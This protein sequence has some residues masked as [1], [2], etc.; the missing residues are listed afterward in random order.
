MQKWW[1]EKGCGMNANEQ[2]NAVFDD[3][4]EEDKE[5]SGFDSCF[6]IYAIAQRD[7]GT[8]THWPQPSTTHFGADSDL[9]KYTMTSRW[10]IKTS[11]NMEMLG[12]LWLY[13]AL[14]EWLL[15]WIKDYNISFGRWQ[16]FNQAGFT[17]VIAA[18]LS[19]EQAGFRRQ[20]LGQWGSLQISLWF[21]YLIE[22]DITWHNT[23]VLITI[24]VWA[25]SYYFHPC[26]FHHEYWCCAYL[27]HHG[28]S[29]MLMFDQ[30]ETIS[31]MNES[32]D[33]ICYQHTATA[34]MMVT[35]Y[36]NASVV[37]NQV[38]II[39]TSLNQVCIL[40]TPF[41]CYGYNSL[42]LWYRVNVCLK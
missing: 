16:C 18:W 9:L 23:P 31:S 7:N 36:A 21:A 11:L 41:V 33:P 2:S 12:M 30:K 40:P 26:P 34:W 20:F 15:S 35:L 27:C 25:A 13:S 8:V 38:L 3:D 4:M 42:C 24:D 22:H 28:Y 37:Y 17:W 14:D 5:M 1:Y 19:Q 32:H 29:L 39:L 10:G 6:V